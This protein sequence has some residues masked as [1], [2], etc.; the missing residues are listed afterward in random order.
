MI[1]PPVFATLVACLS[2]VTPFASFAQGDGTM[3]MGAEDHARMH[4]TSES[5][6]VADAM[7][8]MMAEM[9]AIKPTGDADADILLMMIPHHRSAVDMGEALLPQID[10][11]EVEALARTIIALQEAEIA[12]MREVLERLG[13][14]AP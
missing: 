1:F 6:E 12:V 14:S 13:H 9:H 11:P 10:D 2:F 5:D 7:D 3:Q 4:A 8:R